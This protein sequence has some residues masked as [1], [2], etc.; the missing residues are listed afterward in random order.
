MLVLLLALWII[1]N[2]RFTPEILIT[3]IIIVAL[4]FLFACKFLKY[5]VKIELLTYRFVPFAIGYLAIL[6][7]EIIKAN[8]EVL[9]LIFKGN[10]KLEPVVY[11]FHCDLNTELARTILANSITLTPGT[12]TISMHD[13]EF[14]VHCLDKSLSEGINES[15]FVERLRRIDSK[16]VSV[17]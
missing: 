9:K 10:N 15:I 3:G 8:F 11:H 5:S 16:I 4:I 17:S 6:I 7:K 1:F 2:G 14:Y 13:N 12:I